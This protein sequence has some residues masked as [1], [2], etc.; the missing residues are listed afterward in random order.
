M[1]A[2]ILVKDDSAFGHAYRQMTDVVSEF[3]GGM[4]TAGNSS[5]SEAAAGTMTEGRDFMTKERQGRD[6]LAQYMTK[7]SDGLTG[8]QNAVGALG[9]EHLKLVTLNTKRLKTIMYPTDAPVPT[10]SA[11]DPALVLANQ[12][13]EKG[14]H[15]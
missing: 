8:Y 10:D 5:V 1:E 4:K 6:L 2:D 12:A 11:F 14:G 9:H 15:R 3:Q 7:T 13:A